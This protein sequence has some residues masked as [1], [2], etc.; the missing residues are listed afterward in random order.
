MP[1]KLRQA[2]TEPVPADVEID[3]ALGRRISI[4]DP[5]TVQAIFS[6]FDPDSARRNDEAPRT[7]KLH[8]FR[9]YFPGR[10]S[11]DE[12]QLWDSSVGPVWTK[13][14]GYYRT[15]GEIAPLMAALP[16]IRVAQLTRSQ[17]A[18]ER[19]LGRKL[20]A[21]NNTE[22]IARLLTLLDSENLT[23]RGLAMNNL[24]PLLDVR[25]IHFGHG[26]YQFD[27]KRDQRRA[28]AE[29]FAATTR[30][31][32]MRIVRRTEAERIIDPDYRRY[33]WAGGLTECLIEV[34]DQSTANEFADQLKN[35]QPSTPPRRTHDIDGLLTMIET[36]YGLPPTY[37][38]P[39]MCGNS[40]AEEFARFAAEMAPKQA[41][42]KATLLDWHVKHGAKPRSEQ[43]QAILEAWR[44]ELLKL[45]ATRTHYY[46][47]EIAPTKDFLR[48]LR[49][50][51]ELIPAIKLR[52]SKTTDLAE[53][54][55]LEYIRAYLEGDCDAAVVDELLAGNIPQQ[56]LACRIIGVSGRRD[57]T[58]LL[59]RQQR[60]KL[61]GSA[62]AEF[63]DVES[64]INA[65]GS[66]LWLT[67]GLDSLP[68]LRAAHADG[69]TNR[70]SE[71]LVNRFDLPG[72]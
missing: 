3:I 42:A 9:F 71:A 37:D 12:L 23:V 30:D 38:P 20:R 67:L 5:A 51:P 52:Q 63:Y 40:S 22:N 31:A 65:A 41:A 47:P 48:L 57:W 61:V 4:N 21:T 13:G 59:D 58:D 43:L 28:V 26:W 46:E 24:R 49:I 19:E 15:H 14:G 27:I 68:L 44:P 34:A 18:G 7:A 50:G 70:R 72:R 60:R 11:R 36:I 17:T 62:P 8:T 45:S 10:T 6:L 55:G 33:Q 64:Q 2:F 39:E 25:D 32:L 35:T 56:A 69:F 29:P 53:R 1:T 66:A 54:S 16:A